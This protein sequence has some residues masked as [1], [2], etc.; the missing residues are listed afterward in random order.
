MLAT[1]LACADAPPDLAPG[2]DL[3]ITHASVLDVATGTVLPDRTVVI[4]GGV[5]TAVRQGT[6]PNADAATVL[7]ARGRLLTRGFIDAHFHLCNVYGP[8]H[9][10][11]AQSGRLQGRRALRGW[12]H[13]VVKVLKRMQHS[14]GL[15]R[16]IAKT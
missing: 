7:D 5:I 10:T 14:R 3:V 13:D 8:P 16:Q 1:L 2:G 15:R 4:T 6:A 9:C 12:H 11:S